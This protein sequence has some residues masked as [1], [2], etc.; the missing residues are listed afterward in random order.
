VLP[1]QV[2]G[3]VDVIDVLEVVALLMVK[4]RF[5]VESHPLEAVDRNE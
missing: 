3:V 5:A 2:Y 1:F 4:A